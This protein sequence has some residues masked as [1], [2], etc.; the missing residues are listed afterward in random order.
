MRLQSCHCSQLKRQSLPSAS[1]LTTL[2]ILLFY[3]NMVILGS[4]DVE[5][6]GRY[7]S[8]ARVGYILNSHTIHKISRKVV[9][10]QTFVSGLF[11]SL[12]ITSIKVIG[13]DTDLTSLVV[14][15]ESYLHE[16]LATK[17]IIQ[18][19][20]QLISPSFFFYSPSFFGLAMSF[21]FT[22]S[23]YISFALFFVKKIAVS[24]KNKSH[25]SSDLEGDKAV[26]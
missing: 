10:S 1:R 8:G 18:S 4:N 24:F 11:W 15:E 5:Q 23:F 9:L 19:T 22:L 14:W 21:Y 17:L 26:D 13:D 3:A 7:L 16:K 20:V 2:L 25:C 12:K 6:S